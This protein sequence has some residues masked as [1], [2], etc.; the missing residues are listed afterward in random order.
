MLRCNLVRLVLCVLVQLH[1]KMVRQDPVCSPRGKQ[2]R[3]QQRRKARGCPTTGGSTHRARLVVGPL[4]ELY[5]SLPAVGGEIRVRDVSSLEVG[6]GGGGG[7]GGGCKGS[8]HLFVVRLM[9]LMEVGF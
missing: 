7:G 2:Q 8:A 3:A 1:H 5:A 9:R 6:G 4:P